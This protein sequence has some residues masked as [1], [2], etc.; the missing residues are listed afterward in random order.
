LKPT[1]TEPAIQGAARLAVRLKLLGAP[2]LAVGEQPLPALAAIDVALLAILALQGA[3]PRQQVSALLWPDADA[4]GAATNLRQHI[5][6]L[7]RQAGRAVV[8][9][10]RTISLPADLQ[11]D[12]QGY[13]ER[14]A[15]DPLNGRGALLGAL[16]FLDQ[17]ALAAWL[18]ARREALAQTRVRVLTQAA[19]THAEQGR[20]APAVS[21]AQAWLHH[22]PVVEQ[23]HRL[24]IQLLYQQGNRAAALAAYRQCEHVL[25][26]E[27]G[28]EP[29]APRQALLAQLQAASAPA[30]AVVTSR[31]TEPASRWMPRSASCISSVPARTAAMP[32]RT[33]APGNGATSRLVRLLGK[34]WRSWRPTWPTHRTMPPAAACS[35]R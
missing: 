19:H 24:C 7:K 27:L 28:V 26:A 5:Y 8:E 25:R 32:W 1:V 10:D 31:K 34:A 2:A 22:A 14:L 35:S 12:L 33:S 21:F 15:A 9:G 11:H 3:Q 16:E 30:P 4:T 17:D 29:S 6:R 23:A 20:L 13:A 18:A